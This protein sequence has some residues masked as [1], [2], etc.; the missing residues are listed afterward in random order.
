MTR[1]MPMRRLLL[2]VSPLYR[3]ALAAREFRLRHG[4]EPVFRLNDPVISIGNLSTGGSGKTPFVIALARALTARG[5]GV[6][7]LSRGYG[8]RSESPAR[9]DP[10]G[11]PEDFGDEPLLITRESGVPVYVGSQRYDAGLLAEAA[12]TGRYSAPGVPRNPG[13]TEGFVTGHDFNRADTP[14]NSIGASAPEGC[15]LHLLDDA[16]QHRQLHRDVDILL[17]NHEDW[18]DRLLPAGN[19]REPLHAINRADLIAIPD[20]EPGLEPQ[21]RARGW[22]GPIW[23]IHRHM[24]VPPIDG[25]AVTFCGIARP[26][27][28]FA[29]LEASGLHLAARLAFRD[30]HHYTPGDLERLR[31]AARS[32]GATA[33]ITTAKDQVRLAAIPRPPRFDLSVLTA[34]LRI[35]IDDEAVA[36]DWLTRR[37]A[38]AKSRPSL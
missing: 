19:L 31:Q 1:A 17:L 32:A 27:Q 18:H 20:T 34:G 14:A 21:L 35:E 5:Y 36:L 13:S 6:D 33:L 22:N 11:N 9:V 16:F 37:L 2:P 15:R 24:E 4:W 38:D 26:A 8:R 10:R 12:A 28:F 30:H 3:L 25:P 23:R 29:G 7:V